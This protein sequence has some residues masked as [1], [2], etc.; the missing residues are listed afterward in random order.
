MNRV[1]TLVNELLNFGILQRPKESKI[2]GPVYQLQTSAGVDPLQEVQSK[3]KI[4][5]LGQDQI[6]RTNQRA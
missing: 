2:W 5:L 4:P 1:Q 3:R 6:P